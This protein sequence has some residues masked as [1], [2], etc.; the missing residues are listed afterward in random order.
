MNVLITGAGRGIG[1]ALTR[2]FLNEGHPV[3]A[4]SRNIEELIKIGNTNLTAYSFDLLN[5]DFTPLIKKVNKTFGN[6]DIL[7]NNAGIVVVKPLLDFSDEDFDRLFNVN[8]KAAYKMVKGCVPLMK[9]GSH[10]VNIS[11]IG[12]FQGSVKFPGLALYSASKGAIAVLTESMAVEL[13]DEK[14][15]VNA[16]ALG[17]VQTEMLS[18]AFPEYK[19]P[20]QP[21]EMA[22]FIKDFALT[23]HKVYN[24]KILPVSLSTP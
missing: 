19:A 1:L 8:V 15:S 14:I 6:L 10:I 22:S 16:L 3:L 13:A 4:V 24:G 21:H 5:N 9:Q 7:I 12:G 17:A 20:L 23:G 18:T 2:A 11:S